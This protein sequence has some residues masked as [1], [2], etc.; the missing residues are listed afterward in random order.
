MKSIL[1]ITGRGGS[2]EKGLAVYLAGIADEF[3]SQCRK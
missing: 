3:D 2:L 1:Y